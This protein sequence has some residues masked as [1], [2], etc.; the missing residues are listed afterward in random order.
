MHTHAEN[1]V[2]VQTCCHYFHLISHYF[3]FSRKFDLNMLSVLSYVAWPSKC[4]I[5]LEF[6]NKVFSQNNE[7]ITQEIDINVDINILKW[8]FIYLK[9]QDIT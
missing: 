6:E 2:S 5:A 1:A 4:D 9:Q 8:Q 7:M 3:T